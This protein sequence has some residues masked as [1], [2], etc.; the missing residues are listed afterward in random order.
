LLIGEDLVA[1]APDGSHLVGSAVTMTRQR[2]NLR[3]HVGLNDAAIARL[4]SENPRSA[5]GV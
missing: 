5:I 3:E 4:T 2:E 1:R